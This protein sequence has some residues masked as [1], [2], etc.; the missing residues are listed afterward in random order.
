LPFV[1]LNPRKR[2]LSQRLA[3]R[4]GHFA[5]ASLLDS[6]LDTLELPDLS[7][8]ALIIDNETSIDASCATIVA[9]LAATP[10]HY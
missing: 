4:K 2:V 6:Q 8:R 9:W 7:E 1:L 3:A 10:P 5:P